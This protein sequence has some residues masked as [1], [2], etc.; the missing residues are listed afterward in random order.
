MK[1]LPLSKKADWTLPEQELLKQEFQSA[2]KF[3]EVRVGTTH[4]FY[5]SFIRAR[6]IPLAEC[7]RIFLRV[8][9]GEYG[10]LPIH[11]HYVVVKTKQD[12]ELVLRM[13]RPSDAKELLAYLE[14]MHPDIK[15]G[16]EIN[17]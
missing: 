10:D 17:P 7:A 1:I 8:E 2:K 14:E 3:E 16:K 9:M 4:L 13:E 5:R 15:F 12:E 11:E 6:M